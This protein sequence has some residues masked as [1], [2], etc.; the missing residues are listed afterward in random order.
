MTT[1]IHNGLLVTVDAERRIILDGA[2]AM[3][4]NRIAETGK[5]RDLLAKYP[6]ATRIDAK[7]GIIMPGLVDAH[8]HLSQG[9]MRGLGAD[10]AGRPWV[11][12]RLRPCEAAL[13]Q[14]DAVAGAWQCLLE[15]LMS[16]ST[17][18]VESMFPPRFGGAVAGVALE[19]RMR[20]PLSMTYSGKDDAAPI[21]ELFK[22]FDGKSDK[23]GIFTA[24]RPLS[25]ISPEI[26][27]EGGEL[28]RELGTKMSWH[29]QQ[30]P[31]AAKSVVT[32]AD[33]L[34][35]LWPGAL[36]GHSVDVTDEDIPLMRERGVHVVT[37]PTTNAK[38]GMKSCPVQALLSGGVN[39]AIGTDGDNTRDMFQTM[40]RVAEL[41]KLRRRDGAVVPVEAAIEMATL[42]GARALGLEHEIGS[43]EAGKKADLIVVDT[44]GPWLH[45]LDNPLCSL[46]YGAT[47]R[48][49]SL[50]I[51][52]GEVLVR[53]GVPVFLDPDQIIAHATE[54]ASGLFQRAN[55]A[56]LV[57]PKWPIF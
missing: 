54:A 36:L 6:E 45:P 1:V 16:G 18:V 17:T 47:G 38:L 9:V 52:D 20:V 43:L 55:I 25:A 56:P 30:P 31:N 53:D 8:V 41:E 28:A 7:G 50:V 51:V 10:V 4:G 46:V 19:S 29:F 39:V 11:A 13:T 40:A 34:G 24:L 27:R 15:S 5:A 23:V 26:A 35:L 12:E 3:E 44:R 21:T 14:S 2:V 32:V 49:V 42:G 37:L 33:E 57:R 22:E 48:D